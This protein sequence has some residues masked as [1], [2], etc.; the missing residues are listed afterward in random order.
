MSPECPVF[1]LLTLVT[2]DDEKL[3]SNKLRIH[4]FQTMR[5]F[6]FRTTLQTVRDRLNDSQT[7]FIIKMQNTIF[8]DDFGL[9]LNHSTSPSSNTSP[10][11][12]IGNSENRNLSHDLIHLH[13]NYNVKLELERV[14]KLIP[15][16]NVLILISS[17]FDS[18]ILSMIQRTLWN[19]KSFDLIVKSS[20]LFL[21]FSC[22]DYRFYARLIEFYSSLRKVLSFNLGSTPQA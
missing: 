9:K 21:S 14:N 13:R 5:E 3:F 7:V 1:S 4:R 10:W 6:N 11:N 15:S 2:A 8:T 17:T 20:F 12:S 22:S 16:K 19:L 18:N